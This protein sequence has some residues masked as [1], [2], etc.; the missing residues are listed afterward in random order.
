MTMI[1]YDILWLSRNH[2]PLLGQL[3]NVQHAVLSWKASIFTS[4]G[5]RGEQGEPF[6]SSP[7]PNDFLFTFEM[8]AATP[9]AKLWLEL[10]DRVSS[11]GHGRQEHLAAVR[12]SNPH[13]V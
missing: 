8:T 5:I 3:W 6:T 1:Y 10:E 11:P 13:N 7:V 4:Q 9:P 2:E 12:Q